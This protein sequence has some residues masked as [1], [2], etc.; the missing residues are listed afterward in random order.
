MNI[1]DL[2]KTVEQQ[3]LMQLHRQTELLTIIAK[4]TAPEIAVMTEAKLPKQQQ[5]RPSK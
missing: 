4:Q 3:M 5:R 1:Q 2:P